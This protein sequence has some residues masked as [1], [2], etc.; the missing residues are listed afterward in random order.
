MDDFRSKRL[1]ATAAVWACCVCASA[2]T[3]GAQETTSSSFR[4]LL[5]TPAPESETR[6]F[7]IALAAQRE[8]A[9]ENEPFAEPSDE[10]PEGVV[11]A[12]VTGEQSPVERY[13]E[14]PVDRTPQFLRQ[15][16]PL[17]EAGQWQVDYGL[18][19][20]LQESD[21]P[22]LVGLNLDRADV[23]RRAWL[24]PFALRYGWNDRTQLFANLPVGFTDTETATSFRDES[25]SDGGIGDITFGV[26][27]LLNQCA[28]TGRSTI[29][30]VRATAPTGETVNPLVFYEQGLGNGVWQL[31]ADLLHVQTLDPVILFYGAGYTYSFEDEFDGHEVRLGH[32][33][34]YNFGLGFAANERVT[35]STAFLGSYITE[36]E[37]N[38]R[39]VPNSDLEPLRVRMA[40]T[41]AGDCKLIEPFVTF[42]LTE[43]APSAE[44]GVVWTL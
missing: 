33:V 6:R 2:A 4:S 12:P 3:A 17:L 29:A 35:L 34:S 18:V 10:Q 13:G 5:E 39:Y 19:Y 7:G 28:A 23:R 37:L 42:G 32:Q 14:A 30:T 15:V 11:P 21:F 40:A 27:R 24:S 44:L 38:D 1:I 25:A 36:T 43:T 16:T 8:A 22:T 31:G 26:T 9:D 20:F 41:I